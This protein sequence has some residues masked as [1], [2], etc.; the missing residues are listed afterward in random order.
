MKSLSRRFLV[1]IGLTSLIL[2]LLTTLAGF[3]VF[4]RELSNRQVAYL[5]DYVA[6]RTSNVERRFSNLAALHEAA[7][8][9]L[10]RRMARLSDAEVDRLADEYFPKRPDG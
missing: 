7:G 1:S 6:E 8:E 4:Q 10:A 9:E 5:Q 3:L 2:T